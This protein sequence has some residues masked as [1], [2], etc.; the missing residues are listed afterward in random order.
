MSLLQLSGTTGRQ[1]RIH[2][3]GDDMLWSECWQA[4]YSDERKWW[5]QQQ[6]KAIDLPAVVAED[7]VHN[8]KR[9]SARAVSRGSSPAV[10]LGAAAKTIPY[11][12]GRGV[13]AW[14]AVYNIVC[15]IL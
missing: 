11:E 3:S 7:P 8:R 6:Q 9:I 4:N 2:L 15:N 13:P 12:V 14:N 10:C 5:K 1:R